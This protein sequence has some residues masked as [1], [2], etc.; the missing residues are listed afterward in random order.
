MKINRIETDEEFHKAMERIESLHAQ[1]H[2]PKDD[3]RR[4]Q[5]TVPREVVKEMV[6]LMIETLKYAD[7]NEERRE[8]LLRPYVERWDRLRDGAPVPQA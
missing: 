5:P 8:E 1:Y 3:P 2:I 7:Q 4:Y 6:D